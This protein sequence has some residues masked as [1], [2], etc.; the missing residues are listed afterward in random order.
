[1]DFIRSYWWVLVFLLVVILF[2]VLFRKKDS[3]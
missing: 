3:G 2:A 1:M